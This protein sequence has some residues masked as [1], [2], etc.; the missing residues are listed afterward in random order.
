MFSNASRVVSFRPQSDSCGP[1]CLAISKPGNVVAA[2]AAVLGDTLAADVPQLLLDGQFRLRLAIAA[3]RGLSS[4]LPPERSTPSPPPATCRPAATEC[5]ARHT[6]SPCSRGTRRAGI[7]ASIGPTS[8]SFISGSGCGWYPAVACC[9]RNSAISSAG[10]VTDTTWPV[11]SRFW[12]G[13]Q[14]QVRHDGSRQVSSRL[15][16]EVGQPRAVR[17]RRRSPASAQVSRPRRNRRPQVSRIL[18]TWRSRHVRGRETRAQ[19]GRETRAQQRSTCRPCSTDRGRPRFRPGAELVGVGKCRVAVAGEAAPRLKQHSPAFRLLRSGRIGDPGRRGGRAGILRA[20]EQVG[21][22]TTNLQR[23]VLL[24]QLAA[25]PFQVVP[26]SERARHAGGRTESLRIAQPVV[27]ERVCSLW[28]TYRRLGPGRRSW[29]GQVLRGLACVGGVRRLGP[30]VGADAAAALIT[31]DLVA[32]VAPVGANQAVPRSSFGAGGCGNR[33]LGRRSAT[34][35]WHFRQVLSMNRPGMHGIVPERVVEPAVL[36]A[37]AL[38]V[39]QSLGACDAHLNSVALPCPSWQ[40]VQANSDILCGTEFTDEQVQPGV[41][42]KGMRQAAAD[43][44]HQWPAPASSE[45]R[46]CFRTAR[47]V[48]LR[49]PAPIRALIGR[50]LARGLRP[51]AVDRDNHVAGP[52]AWRDARGRRDFPGLKQIQQDLIGGAGGRGGVARAA[53]AAGCRRTDVRTVTSGMDRPSSAS[54]RPRRWSSDRSG[55]GRRTVRLQRLPRRGGQVR[56]PVGSRL[57]ERRTA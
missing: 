7:R 17:V 22:H 12:I 14:Q 41:A 18:E 24:C 49:Q 54:R 38:P 8:V 45:A 4:L 55:V 56:V 15:A 20:I 31:V 3:W 33:W 21:D 39:G 1:I 5:L 42:G 35:W 37:P 16:D 26:E 57:N 13:F 9:S 27:Q 11:A 32:T 47:L 23:L 50:S 2:E 46:A 34:R 29:P 51:P 44:Q 52:Q 30:Q 43:R 6:A 40:I 28:P 19:Q 53:V 48:R 10:S 25:V 36:L